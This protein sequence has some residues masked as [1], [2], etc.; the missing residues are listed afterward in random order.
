MSLQAR[1]HSDTMMSAFKRPSFQYER[2]PARSSDLQSL[3]TN[4]LYRGCVNEHHIQR[5]VPALARYNSTTAP[6][7][8]ASRRQILDAAAIASGSLVL[9][10]SRPAYASTYPAVDGTAADALP[11]VPH[12]P[13]VLNSDIQISRVIKGCW[14]LSGGH[15]GEKETDRTGGNVAVQVRGRCSMHLYLAL[16][17]H[18]ANGACKKHQHGNA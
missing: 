6:V 8:K 2:A 11:L 7:V 18:T 16:W 10:Y 14:Q 13:L 4:R 17:Y 5:F 3:E 12:T 1:V 9:P 15:K